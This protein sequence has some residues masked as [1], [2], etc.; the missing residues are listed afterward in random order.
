MGNQ[1]L[2]ITFIKDIS[3]IFFNVELQF[4]NTL[5]YD[6]L[7]FT[8]KKERDRDGYS[9]AYSTHTPSLHSSS[10]FADHIFLSL[11]P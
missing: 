2:N 9:I 6:R 4:K 11:D 5:H 1:N 3:W 7:F 10:T 8:E